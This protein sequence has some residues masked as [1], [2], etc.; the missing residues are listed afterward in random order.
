MEYYAHSENDK[1][2]GVSDPLLDHLNVVARLS[3]RF[4]TFFKAKYVKGKG[5]RKCLVVIL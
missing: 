5:S 4:A 2:N 3:K 1:C